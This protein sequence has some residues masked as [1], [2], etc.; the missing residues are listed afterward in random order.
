MGSHSAAWIDFAYHYDK[1]RPAYK[2]GQNMSI[3]FGNLPQRHNAQANELPGLLHWLSRLLTDNFLN[4]MLKVTCLF[5]MCVCCRASVIFWFCCW[6][7]RWH[8][9]V[10]FWL[11][12]PRVRTLSES[13]FLILLQALGDNVHV[14][15]GGTGERA[16]LHLQI[17]IWCFHACLAEPG[18][19]V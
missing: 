12:S 14:S 15:L 11:E 3:M 9:Q 7:L 5:L 19:C 4:V 13:A 6:H 1:S 2:A 18:H 17:I 8:Q 10:L 16:V